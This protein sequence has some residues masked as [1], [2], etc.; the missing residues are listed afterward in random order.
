MKNNQKQALLLFL[1]G[2]PL[3][4]YQL[5][6]TTLQTNQSCSVYS[7][8]SNVLQ[9]LLNFHKAIISEFVLNF[10]TKLQSLNVQA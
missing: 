3:Q 6:N 10:T 1:V 9:S 7:T 4:P 8:V 5:W 2:I